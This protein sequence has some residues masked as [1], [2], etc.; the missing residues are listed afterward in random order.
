MRAIDEP[1]PS[2][3]AGKRN[4]LY[5]GKGLLSCVPILCLLLFQT[6]PMSSSPL[7][8][9]GSLSPAPSD[10]SDFSIVSDNMDA[11]NVLNP[12]SV[13]APQVTANN[14]P[15]PP[16][17]RWYIQDDNV[18]FMVCCLNFVQLRH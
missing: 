1:G 14:T 10:F 17:P 3:E 12:S 6:I 11:P 13:P 8:S 15:H 18:E 5:V 16:H 7:G 2:K 9:V 4:S